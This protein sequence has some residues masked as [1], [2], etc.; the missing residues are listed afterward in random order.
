MLYEDLA[1]PQIQKKFLRSLTETIVWCRETGNIADPKTSLRT[2]EPR[3]APLSSQSD[4]VSCVSFDRSNRLRSIGM[5][6]LEAVTDLRGGRLLAYFPDDT[7]SDGVAAAES[8]GFFDDV[9]IP[10]YD[11][12]VWMVQDV[13]TVAYADGYKTEVPANFLVAWVPPV[14]IELANDGF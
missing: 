2:F 10:P 1:R 13:R 3:C 9:N 11:T 4:Q 5:D 8:N 14:F 7:L 12:W 6:D